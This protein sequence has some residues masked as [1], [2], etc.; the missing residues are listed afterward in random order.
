MS[1]QGPV[2][3][4]GRSRPSRK[5]PCPLSTPSPGRVGADLPPR[6]ALESGGHGRVEW[7]REDSSAPSPGAQVHAQAFSGRSGLLGHGGAG[8]HR[9]SLYPRQPALPEGLFP[10]RFPL[11]VKGTETWGDRGFPE[12]VTDWAPGKVHSPGG[13]PS[14]GLPTGSL[15][16]QRQAGCPT[17]SH[18]GTTGPG[19]GIR[20]GMPRANAWPLGDME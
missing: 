6:P 10:L 1:P 17:G 8:G 20:D 2:L 9:S 11:P 3:G 12:W 13:P 19:P 4:G 15:L 14:G 18:A 5:G 16:S 7:R